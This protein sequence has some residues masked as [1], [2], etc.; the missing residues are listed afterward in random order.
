MKKTEKTAEKKVRKARK[1]RR[2]RR[3]KRT[4]RVVN[5]YCV[6]VAVKKNATMKLSI[7]ARSIADAVKIVDRTIKLH[8]V[9]VEEIK[10]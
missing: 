5:S 3:S 10:S 2:H 9:A 7:L 6:T 1:I 4:A 8:V